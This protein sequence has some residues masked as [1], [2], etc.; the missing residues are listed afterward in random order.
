[1]KSPIVIIATIVIV[2]FILIGVGYFLFA[3]DRSP[4]ESPPQGTPSAEQPAPPRESKPASEK[5]ALSFEQ[6]METLKKA[7]A[8][9]CAGGE[10][11]E[12]TLVFTEAEANNQAAKLLAQAEV[13]DIPLEIKSVHIDFQADNSLAIEAKTVAYGFEV[14]IKV[15]AQVGIEEGRPEVEVSNIS[16]GFVPLPKSLKDEIVGLITQKIDDLLSQLTQTNVA[17]DGKVDLEFTHINI[18]ESK[19]TSTVIIK[20]RA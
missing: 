13:E 5:P 14:M 7:V 17:C 3:S 2:L 6:K 18:S 10:S 12:V 15:K 9:V 16:F 19:A 8:D 1:M 20:P 11:K 4:T